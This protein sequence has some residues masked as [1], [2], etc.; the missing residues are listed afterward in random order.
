MGERTLTEIRRWLAAT[1]WHDEFS[2]V[3]GRLFRA[4]GDEVDPGDLI[5]AATYRFGARARGAT[6][7]VAVTTSAG[8]PAGTLLT[9]E[10]ADSTV[11]ASLRPPPLPAEDIR[12]HHAHD[13]LAAIF[14][15]RGQAEAAVTELRRL[16]LGSEHLGLAVRQ[17][18]AVVFEHDEEAE[19]ERD[20][21]LG[22]AAGAPIGVLAGMAL[23][24]IAVP[25]LGVL[26]IA[27]LL[28]V[29]AATSVGGAMLGGYLGVA[30][31]ARA[32][33][34]HDHLS[35]TPLR[36]GEVLVVVSSHG[37]PDVARA[38]LVGAG[39]ELLPSPPSPR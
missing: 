37:H 16:G 20:S 4:N 24:L 7:L 13:H 17:P 11:I 39:G 1:G 32:I 15:T 38:A 8:E 22:A 2:V 25:G 26:G 3:D 18:E 14:P 28:A 12:S 5:A 34:E 31:A 9:V 6:T 29:G 36:E 19:L 27:G 30:A 10:S 23:V 33:S 35:Q 21:G